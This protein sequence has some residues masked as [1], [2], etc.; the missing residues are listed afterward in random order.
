MRFLNDI[1]FATLSFLC[2]VLLVINCGKVLHS[3][4]SLLRDESGVMKCWESE[5]AV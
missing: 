1:S 4:E 2:L 3:I 5:M